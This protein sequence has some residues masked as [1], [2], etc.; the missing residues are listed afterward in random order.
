MNLSIL[1][2]HGLFDGVLLQLE[3]NQLGLYQNK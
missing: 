1:R 2:H 3:G